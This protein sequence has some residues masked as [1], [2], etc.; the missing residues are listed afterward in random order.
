MEST[1]NVSSIFVRTEL[2]ATNFNETKS[3]YEAIKS[4]HST[5]SE[6]VKAVATIAFVAIAEAIVYIAQSLANVVLNVNNYFADRNITTVTTT[7]EEPAKSEIEMKKAADTLDV[8]ERHLL[9]L[10]F[11]PEE[12]ASQPAS[13]A[14]TVIVEP[15]PQQEAVVLQGPVVEEA[16]SAPQQEVVV[17]QQAEAAP[18]LQQEEAVAEQAPVVQEEVT[19][20]EEAEAVEEKTH[21]LSDD[22]ASETSSVASEEDAV[23]ESS[24][25]SEVE[26][27]DQ[28]DG[29]IKQKFDEVVDGITSVWHSIASKFS[30]KAA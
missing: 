12:T 1:K 15:A 7:T 27:S 3:R 22:D 23:S 24:E 25:T 21:E 18:A 17:A 16:A 13:A 20:G 6:K 11:V 9:P 2:Y 10:E 19:R 5:T 26:D 4:D 28:E 29:I 8:A 14:S 30:K